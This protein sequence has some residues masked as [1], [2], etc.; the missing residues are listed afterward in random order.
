ML[1]VYFFLIV[2]KKNTKEKHNGLLWLEQQ[3]SV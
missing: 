3:Q 2:A 1:F